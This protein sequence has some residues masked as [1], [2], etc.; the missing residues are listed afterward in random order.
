MIGAEPK[1]KK[2]KERKNREK[3]TKYPQPEHTQR[4]EKKS[5]EGGKLGANSGQ[6]MGKVKS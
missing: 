5:R 1:R 4:K 3:I 2:K 6:R